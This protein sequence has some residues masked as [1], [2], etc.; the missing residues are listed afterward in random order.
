M[1][2]HLTWRYRRFIENSRVLRASIKTQRNLQFIEQVSLRASIKLTRRLNRKTTVLRAR[3]KTQTTLMP[4]S[5]L[6]LV[7]EFDQRMGADS[8]IVSVEDTVSIF[9]T[10][11]QHHRYVQ[12]KQKTQQSQTIII[13][14]KKEQEASNTKPTPKNLPRKSKK[15]IRKEEEESKK[16]DELLNLLRLWQTQQT[17]PPNY[18]S[19]QNQQITPGPAPKAA[20]R[21]H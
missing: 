4:T 11:L 2:N 5:L 21:H 16:N 10:L 18:N 13:Q 1:K 15:Q 7:Q 3:I 19:C 8:Q 14:P 17:P 12:H 6:E 20:A 9:A